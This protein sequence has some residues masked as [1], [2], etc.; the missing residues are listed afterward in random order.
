M[1]TDDRN[2]PAAPDTAPAKRGFFSELMQDAVRVAAKMVIAFATATAIAAGVC[3]YYGLPLY[4]ALAG[5][6][7]IL[8]LLVVLLAN[9]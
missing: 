4:Y 3:L 8:I 5:G 1:V 2:R 6:V 7:G 9:A